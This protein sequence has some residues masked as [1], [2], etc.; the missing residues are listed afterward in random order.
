MQSSFLVL[1]YKFVWWLY[2]TGGGLALM[3][4]IVLNFF[5]YNATAW[6]HHRYFVLNLSI[7]DVN[8]VV[9]GA[10]HL[11]I[12]LV[13]NHY[14][15]EIRLDARPVTSNWVNAGKAMDI[16]LCIWKGSDWNLDWQSCVDLGMVLWLPVV[17]LVM[18]LCW[19]VVGLVMFSLWSFVGLVI[20]LWW[21]VVGLLMVLW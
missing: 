12:G 16:L 3:K 5:A 21:P 2:Y 13:C 4:R 11:L 15:D 14:I 7:P 6:H 20:V 19:S 17:G 18:V 1:S 10:L 8:T 9:C